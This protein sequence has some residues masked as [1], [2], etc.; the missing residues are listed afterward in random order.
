MTGNY[1]Y[2][3]KV[4]FILFQSNINSTSGI[5]FQVIVDV[6]IYQFTVM[7]MGSFQMHNVCN[8]SCIFFCF[9][10]LMYKHQLCGNIE[11]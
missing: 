1:Q 8:I 5:N 7:T 3:I 10:K 2:F 9:K 6:K 4:Y 11:A